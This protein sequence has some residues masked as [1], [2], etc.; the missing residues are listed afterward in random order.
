[1]AETFCSLVLAPMPAL[2]ESPSAVQRNGAT[3]A[4]VAVVVVV[5][6]VD[7]VDVV[8]VDDVDGVEA[9]EAVGA[10]A[11][12]VVVLEV[13]VLVLVPPAHAAPTRTHVASATT[14]QRRT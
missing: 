3:G 10:G 7:V 5:V 13:A 14:R 6:D 1:M 11:F 4:T 12:A 9:V 8:D 2:Y